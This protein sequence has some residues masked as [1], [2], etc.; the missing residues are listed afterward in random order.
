MDSLFTH[1][2]LKALQ[3]LLCNQEDSGGD[4]EEVNCSF[5][6]KMKPSD[7]VSERRPKNEARSGGHKEQT[8]SIWKDDEV[9]EGNEYE[10][11]HDPRPQPQYELFYKQAVTTEDIYLQMGMK[12]PTTAS[13]EFLVARIMLP[14]CQKDDLTLDIKSKFLDL[15][16]PQYKLGLHLPNPVDP[17]SGKAQWNEESQV[18]EVTMRNKREFDFM[19]E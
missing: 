7:I 17:D 6:A 18:L 4:D 2:N 15:R 3:E 14:G 12:N 8:D 1:D 9:P 16:T 10:E 19:N 11:I 13:C 5:A